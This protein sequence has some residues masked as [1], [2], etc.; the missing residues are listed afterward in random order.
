MELLGYKM[1]LLGQ[2]T[3]LCV[4]KLKPCENNFVEFEEKNWLLGQ[5]IKVLDG[6]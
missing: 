5:K 2:N 1:K 4:H 3:K 6:K